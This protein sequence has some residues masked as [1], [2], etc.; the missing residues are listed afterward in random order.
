MWSMTF[1][2]WNESLTMHFQL[3]SNSQS[4]YFSL[5]GVRIMRLCHN[6]Y[7]SFTFYLVFCFYCVGKLRALWIQRIVFYYTT[8]SSHSVFVK[9]KLTDAEWIQFYIRYIFIIFIL[10]TYACV[11]QRTTYGLQRIQLRSLDLA[12]NAVTCQTNL[13]VLRA[14]LLFL[15]VLSVIIFE[16]FR[17][18]SFPQ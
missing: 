17:L 4:F 3:A 5:P 2:F 9:V 1:F 8:D 11:G 13:P 15:L 6:T 16:S 12:E 10:C 14:G 7:L 18:A